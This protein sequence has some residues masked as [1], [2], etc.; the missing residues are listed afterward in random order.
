L[1]LLLGILTFFVVLAILVIAHEAGHFG[2][3]KL[4]GVRVEEF[5]V[6]FPPRLRS[7]QRNGTIYSLNAIPLGG[8]V[9]MYGENG[10]TS[11]PDSFGAKPPW[12]RLIILVAGPCMNLL[13]ALILFFVTFAVA[14]PDG[15]TVITRVQPHSPALRSGLHTGD[16]IVAVDGKAVSY[17]S[18]LQEAID[19]HLGQPVNLRVVRG[20]RDL[21]V[22]V[23]PRANPGPGEGPVGILLTQEVMRRYSVTTAAGKAVLAMRDFAVATFQMLISIPHAG[24]SQV[25]GPIGIAHAT[26]QTVSATPRDGITPLLLL[27]AVLSGS[28]GL[29]NLLPIPALDGG[30]VLFV[31]ISWVRRRNVDPEVE[32]LVHLL[33]MT[34]LLLLIILISYQDIIHW[35]NGSSF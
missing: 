10:E 33:G 18:Q 9:K 21:T 22:R 26:T 34:V 19:A 6:G 17:R 13:L 24:A 31:V 5:G 3:A 30:R 29:L 16:R 25:S 35:V 23:V 4:F 28:L 7:W 1:T 27:V 11:S 20:G 14:F 15:S 32:G 2:F 12:Q 8:F